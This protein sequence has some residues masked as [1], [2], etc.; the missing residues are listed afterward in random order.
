MSPS[1]R[2][3]RFSRVVAL[4][5]LAIGVAATAHATTIVK[6]SL[7]EL[8]REVDRIVVGEVVS[9]DQ[10]WD[11]VPAGEGMLFTVSDFRIDRQL[12]GSDDLSHV[13][14]RSPG[15]TMGDFQQHIFAAPVI[16]EEGRRMVLF[17]WDQQDEY[18]SNVAYWEMGQYRVLDDGL[19]ERTRFTEDEFVRHIESRAAALVE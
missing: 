11:V 16:D 17:L 3:G 19:V 1:T 9:V 13:T 10:E 4:S 6:R 2:P 5:A 14:L 7:D 8:I 15:G 12:K 18:L